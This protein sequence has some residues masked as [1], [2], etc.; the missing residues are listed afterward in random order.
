[1]AHHR[2][3][4]YTSARMF[5]TRTFNT[6]GYIN[7]EGKKSHHLAD[8]VT[9]IF[10]S[11]DEYKDIFPVWDWRRLPGIT[12]EQKAE[13]LSP[14]KMQSKGKTSFVGGV[15]DGTYGLA[16]MDFVR[17]TL[18]AKKAWFYF[19]DEFVCLGAGLTC[20]TDNLV[21]TS[22]NQCLLNG[23]VTASTGAAPLAAGE[24]DL[25]DVQWVH[26]DGIGYFFPGKAR[27]HVKA[28]PQTGSWAEI[29]AGSGETVSRDVFSLWL[30]HGKNVTN[31]S[32]QY[33]VMPNVDAAALAA[34]V[35]RN[36]VEILSNTPTLQAVRHKGL[37]LIAAAFW[38]AGRLDAGPGWNV[39]VD[40]PGLLLLRETGDGLQVAVSNPENQALTVNVEIDRALTGN[41]CTS[42]NGGKTRI[43]FDLPGGPQAGSSI[44]RVLKT[45]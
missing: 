11:G 36:A 7:S 22:I 33:I 2:P 27:V 37:K 6:D 25:A 40:K 28:G 24:H 18:S 44:V 3:G 1:M 19:D 16:A 43:Q 14:S 15:S 32:Y 20:P 17:D 26:H 21:L 23:A 34:R 39:N 31:Q 29:G 42:L 10:R 30:E 13:P 45:R 12:A 9:Y 38:Q 5:S 35:E 41:S 4:Y 8:G